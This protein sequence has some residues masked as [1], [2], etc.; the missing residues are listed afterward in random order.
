[1][2]NSTTTSSLYVAPIRNLTQTTA[3]GYNATTSEI[4]YYSLTG[5]AG[6]ASG[7]TV[8]TAGQILTVNF[9]GFFQGNTSYAL[10]TGTTGTT[11]ITTFSFS[12]A[13]SGGQYTIIISITGTAA[14]VPT[15]TITPTPSTTNRCN[16]T[17]VSV[18][19]TGAT[20]PTQTNPKYIVLTVAYDGTN[21]YISASGFNN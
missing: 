13:L 20:T 7:V 21:Y 15:L 8:N 14:A 4:T 19:V 6:T 11:T 17:T 10:T 1:M 16:F 9:N 18:A 12:G 3:L 2:L 5:G